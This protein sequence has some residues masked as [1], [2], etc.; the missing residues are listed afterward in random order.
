[1]LPAISCS[2]NAA[3]L[4]L[5]V[6]DTDVIIDDFFIAKIPPL[7]SIGIS[8]SDSKR[9]GVLHFSKNFCFSAAGRPIAL[10]LPV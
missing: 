3:L 8:L 7:H 9:R 6:E 1:M 2:F 5:K 4:T 10:I